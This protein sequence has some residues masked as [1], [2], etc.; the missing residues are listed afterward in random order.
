MRSIYTLLACIVITG[1]SCKKSFIN[2]TPK[3]SYS[4]ANY[5]QNTQQLSAAVTAAYAPL[6]DVF[7]T[8]YLM[9]EQRSDNTI[10]Q[11]FLSNRGTAYTDREALCEFM[12]ASTDSYTASEW[13]YC[14]QVISRANIVIGR[15]PGTKSVPADTAAIMDGQ[16]KF[17]R[18][19][20]YFKLVRLFGGVPLFVKEVKTA[21]EAFLPRA[22]VDQVYAQITADAND[23]ITELPAPAKFPQTG[24]A[25]KGSATM[26]LADVDVYLKK[27]DSAV[28]LLNTLPAMGYALNANYADAFTPA[29]KNGKE[30]LFE[31]Q[32]LG[33]TTTGSTPNP[34]QFY[35]L[36]RSNSTVLV[37]GV[38]INN[39]STGGWNTPTQDLIG[40]YEPN[41][42]R[43][44]AS[45]G[46][47]EGTYD[48]SNYFTY[49]AVK[50]IL[51]YPGAPTGKIAVPYVKKYEHGAVAVTGSSDDFPLYR[52]SE[53]LLLLAEALNEQ[54]Q[55]PLAP[56]N[57]VRERAGLPDITATNQDTLRAAILHERRIELAFEDKRW[58]DL[59]RSGNA[60]SVM[61]AFGANLQTQITYLPAGAYVVTSDKLLL[62]IPAAEIGV[63]PQLT[64]NHGY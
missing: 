62:P 47:V 12:D 49:S 38:A 10:Y 9:C 61:N 8:D 4:D 25:T 32:F 50:S 18:A 37:T 11:G 43:L 58:H 64:Q 1:V 52:Y 36:P 26:L 55:S 51:N 6:R 24:A 59:V 39:T 20:M 22:T 57:A 45:I 21:D 2:L 33:G 15:L 5:F 35:F 16:C 56:L 23:A 7:T 44:D 14:Y 17:L 53:A 54:G 31:V 30:S 60:I 29:N 27:Y 42:K 48:A 63:N 28:T 3:S 19:L 46:I 40:S 41:D 34:L 13:Q